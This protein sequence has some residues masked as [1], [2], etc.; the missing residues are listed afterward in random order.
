LIF[1]K[2]LA[3]WQSFSI[4]E[5]YFEALAV[6]SLLIPLGLIVMMMRKKR[7]RPSG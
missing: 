2:G 3:V 5:G 6:G 4:F 7:H 1:Y